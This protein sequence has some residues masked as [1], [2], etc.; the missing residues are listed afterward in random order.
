MANEIQERNSTDRLH[1]LGLINWVIC[2]IA[3]RSVHAPRMHLFT[4][5]ARN[6]RLFW[7]WLP[8]SGVLLGRGRLPKEY[9]E[10]VILR[11]AYNSKCKYELQHHRRI[12]Q[13]A[14]IDE[15]MQVAISGSWKSDQLSYHHQA[16]M[17]AVD[18]F[19]FFGE[20]QGTTMN[21][22]ANFLDQRQLVELCM[23]IG[24]YSTLASTIHS[25]GIPLDY[26]E[27]K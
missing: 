2:K 7:A 13:K 9:T 22:L 17:K 14:G 20:I 25:L 11:V 3:A 16:L 27:Q 12:A 6:K 1:D 21:W 5:L 26:Q 23:L 4:T 19:M 10:V 15:R 8:Y 18:N 24:Q